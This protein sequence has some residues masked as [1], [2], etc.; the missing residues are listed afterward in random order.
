MLGFTPWL[1][2]SNL[3]GAC[4]T[5]SVSIGSVSNPEGSGTDPVVNVPVTLSNVVGATVTVNYA[6]AD[7]SGPAGA[8]VPNDYTSTSG[9]VTFLPGV[10]LKRP[11]KMKL[12][13]IIFTSI[14]Q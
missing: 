11:R 12:S 10:E 1:L 2:T 6:T 3:N 5:P 13:L 8:V 14:A 9:T 4:T 7:G